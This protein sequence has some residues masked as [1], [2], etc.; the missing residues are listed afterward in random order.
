MIPGGTAGNVIAARLSEPASEL[1]NVLL[2]EAGP[3]NFDFATIAI[4]FAAGTLSPF[5]P[6][7]WNYTS[8]VQPGLN[9][10]SIPYPRGHVLGGTSST[11]Y[12]V[13]NTGA[14]D[15][16][17]R[18]ANV[19]GDPSWSWDSILPIIKS[20]EALSPPA[21][22][23]DTTGQIKPSLHG[24]SGP[25]GVS[26]QGYPSHID[27]K[28]FK[29]IDE[30]PSEV[31]YNED[32]GSG[33]PLGVGWSLSS[34]KN[35]SR[36]SSAT[37]YLDPALAANRVNLDVLINTQVTRLIPTD[38]SQ[39]AP[40]FLGVE[41]TQSASGKSCLCD[42]MDFQFTI[43][44]LGP[45]HIL[46]ATTEVILSAGAVSTP[47]L[48]MLSGIGDKTALADFNIES[49]AD[50]PDVGRNLQDHTALP[51]VW[52][53]NVSSSPDDMKRN[54]TL[55]NDMLE[56]WATTRTGQLATSPIGPIGW[57]R[58]PDNSSIYGTT[59]DPSAGPATPHYEFIFAEIFSSYV[60]PEPTSGHHMIISS[61]LISPTSRGSITLASASPFD[62]P[63]IDPALLNSDFDIFTMVEAIK[64]AQRFLTAPAW[65]GFVLGQYGLFEGV[66]S[67]EEIEKY[68]RNTAS[69]VF[70]PSSTAYMS[71]FGASHG[72]TNPDF[73]VK[74]TRGLRVVDAS[75]FP[76]VPLMHPQ[77]Y[78]YVLAERAASIIKA[79]KAAWKTADYTPTSQD[80]FSKDNLDL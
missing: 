13:W 6:V 37:A 79:G 15:E 19:T 24:T 25:V 44:S 1:K 10:R 42:L 71:P 52:S 35:G 67:D 77:G 47:Q 57:F 64:A 76:Y 23:H 65:D 48:L 20:I 32:M 16:W 29:A 59:T 49:I 66:T 5:T 62:A 21:D 36:V 61:N 31:F 60:E 46:N 40:A 14:A 50:L 39:D 26:L 55:F 74:G 58:I 53:I 28:V 27:G 11:N 54:T 68:A 70:H 75:V 51:N 7:D 30:L 4:P 43:F 78:I 2:I 69:T 63:L 33:F 17:D 72:V 38:A 34:V 3:S 22:H 12:M 18:Y 9:N 41:F 73:T 45:Y 80:V 8:V 56:E